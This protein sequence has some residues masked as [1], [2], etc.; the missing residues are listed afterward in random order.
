MIT[1]K[2]TLA[3]ADNVL[4]VMGKFLNSEILWA[5]LR[6]VDEI[7]IQVKREREIN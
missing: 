5:E 6:E 3:S 2:T 4:E 7:P 1:M